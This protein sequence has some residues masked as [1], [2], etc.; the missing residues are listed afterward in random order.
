[1]R[2]VAKPP[3]VL[4]K[5]VLDLKPATQAR[6]RDTAQQDARTILRHTAIVS[7]VGLVTLAASITLAVA[8]ELSLF[9]KV[10]LA[11]L[12]AGVGALIF[13]VPVVYLASL[14]LAP[15]RQRREARKQIRE[16]QDELAS[17]AREAGARE[18]AL[19]DQL[20]RAATEAEARESALR[21][22]IKRVGHVT[23]DI[24]HLHGCPRDPARLESFAQTR[25]DGIRVMV[26]QCVECG[27]RAYR[28][29]DVPVAP[30]AERQR[31]PVD[32]L[33]EVLGEGRALRARLML[34]E[35]G[36]WGEDGEFVEHDPVPP[37]EDRLYLWARKALGVLSGE[38]FREHADEFHGKDAEMGSGHFMGAFLDETRERGRKEYLERRIAFLA[39]V[40]ERAR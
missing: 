26:G 8:S 19:R 11:A 5:F 1:M 32:E 36:H 35:V 20:A 3:G 4:S 39:R 27:A 22:E 34:D 40:L 31:T 12:G 2:L 17:A 37:S 13:L 14:A 33:S 21:E 18:T 15:H 16:T 9:P 10:L 25:E 30:P 23:A 24:A 28:H 6:Y 38:R 7:A 29:G